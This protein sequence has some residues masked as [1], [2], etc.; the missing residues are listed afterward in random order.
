[1]FLP[2]RPEHFA[3]LLPAP[4]EQVYFGGPGL[5]VEVPDVPTLSTRETL[6]AWFVSA[7]GALTHRDGR[8]YTDAEL[9]A[10]RPDLSAVDA[11]LRASTG[12]RLA[13]L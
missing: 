2:S 10:R 7:G 8:P 12:R 11:R 6:P 9:D 1:V 4:G 5:V 13:F 3:Y